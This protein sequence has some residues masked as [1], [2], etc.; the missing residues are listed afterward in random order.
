MGSCTYLLAKLCVNSSLPYFNIEAKNEHRGNAKV[1]YVQKVL[2]A[3][4]GHEVWIVKSERH[5]VLVS[6]SLQD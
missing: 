1:S 6:F 5:R 3:V 2:V 4:H